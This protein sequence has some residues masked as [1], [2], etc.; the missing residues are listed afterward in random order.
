MTDRNFSKKPKE[1][2]HEEILFVCFID[3][4]CF[5]HRLICESHRWDKKT[6]KL[7]PM[8]PK[9]LQVDLY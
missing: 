2:L 8:K 6:G 7:L 4:P 3:W 9:S 1:P 5:E